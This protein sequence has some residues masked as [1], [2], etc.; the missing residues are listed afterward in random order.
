MNTP[1]TD[2][3]ADGG[4]YVHILVAQRLETER[5]N[6][7]AE[8]DSLKQSSEFHAKIGITILDAKY[9]DPACHN[10]CQSIKHRAERDRLLSELA[11]ERAKKSDALI[12]AVNDITRLRE[13]LNKSTT[14]NPQPNKQ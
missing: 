10:G 6:A 11:D 9:L 4:N 7:R 8:R 5:N 12:A 1:E 13:A 14:L 2:N 3:A